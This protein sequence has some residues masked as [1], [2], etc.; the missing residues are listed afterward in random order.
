MGA[1]GRWR[2]PI[3]TWMMFVVTL[4]FYDIYWIFDTSGL[5]RQAEARRR[6]GRGPEMMDAA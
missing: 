2:S 1:T 5:A 4:S 6:R 3:R